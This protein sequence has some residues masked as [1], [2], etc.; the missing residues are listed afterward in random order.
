MITIKMIQTILLISQRKTCLATLI[1]HCSILKA[2][3]ED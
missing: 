2:R 3:G 1:V